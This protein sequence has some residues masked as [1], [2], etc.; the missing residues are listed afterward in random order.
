VVGGDPDQSEIFS[1][2]DKILVYAADIGLPGV[3]AA[4]SAL[5]NTVEDEREVALRGPGNVQRLAP[6][7][8]LQQSP[9]IDHAHV[10]PPKAF[11]ENTISG[12]GTNLTSS[13]EHQIQERIVSSRAC[14]S[15]AGKQ[16]GVQPYSPCS[17][18]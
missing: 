9:P 6:S 2:L 8:F 5:S 13:I 3:S 17:F 1:A 11:S 10:G 7:C 12:R 14:L 18:A 16:S 4:I 15:E